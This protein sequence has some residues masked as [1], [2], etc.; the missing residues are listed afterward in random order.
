MSERR[1]AREQSSA[2]KPTNGPVL[3]FQFLPVVNHRAA[4]ALWHASEGKQLNIE[5]LISNPLPWSWTWFCQTDV[6]LKSPQIVLCGG[7]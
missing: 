2:N 6:A 7:A 5:Q 3:M 1:A 4:A